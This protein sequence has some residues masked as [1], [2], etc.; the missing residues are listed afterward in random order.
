MLTTDALPDFPSDEEQ[1]PA[2]MAAI[3]SSHKP[4]CSFNRR[5]DLANLS[6]TNSHGRESITTGGVSCARASVASRSGA[7]L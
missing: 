7:A 1:A 5:K 6:A 2:S 4:A 3:T